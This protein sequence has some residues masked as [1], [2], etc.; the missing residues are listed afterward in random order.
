MFDNIRADAEKK[1][2]DISRYHSGQGRPIITVF[3]AI[4]TLVIIIEMVVAA[5]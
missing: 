4:V 3:F 5:L 1:Q 2:A